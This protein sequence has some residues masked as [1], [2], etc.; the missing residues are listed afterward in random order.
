MH[1]SQWCLRSKD[2]SLNSVCGYDPCLLWESY[3]TQITLWEDFFLRLKQVVHIH[4]ISAVNWTIQGLSSSRG[5]RFFFS[6]T[7]KPAMGHTKTQ[8]QVGVGSFSS[9]GITPGAWIWPLPSNSKVTDKWKSTSASP[10]WRAQ[11]QLCLY[12]Y[13]V[14]TFVTSLLRTSEMVRWFVMFRDLNWTRSEVINSFNAFQMIRARSVLK[15]L[16]EFLPPRGGCPCLYAVGAC[17]CRFEVCVS[18]VPLW[19]PH[20]HNWCKTGGTTDYVNKRPD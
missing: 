18:Y 9:G 13:A 20:C 19:V 4:R 11:G 14:P 8:I 10:L 7:S 15:R 5:K 16:K 3:E 12:L 1:T 17:C 6:K 2:Y